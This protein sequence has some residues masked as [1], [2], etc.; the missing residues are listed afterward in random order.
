MTMMTPD[1]TQAN[2]KPDS[3]TNNNLTLIGTSTPISGKTKIKTGLSLSPISALDNRK[4]LSA[5]DLAKSSRFSPLTVTVKTPLVEKKSVINTPKQQ[6]SILNYV[7]QPS[8][9]SKSNVNITLTNK[10]PCVSGSR[11]TKEQVMAISALANK[12]I[13]SYSNNFNTSVTHLVVD[14]NEDNCVKDHTIK[15]I[16]G[17]AAGIWVVNSK[18]V[19]ECLRQNCLTSE[20]S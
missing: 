12:K 1:I 9:E 18:W 3:N 17:V 8:Q 10:K 4:A 6:Q 14:V 16:S 19:Q 11:L 5:I 13:V 7:Q 20:V 2:T 15:Y